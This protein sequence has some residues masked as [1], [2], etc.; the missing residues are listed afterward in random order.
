[1]ATKPAHFFRQRRLCY[2]DTEKRRFDSFKGSFERHIK[3]LPQIDIYQLNSLDDPD[4]FPCDLLIIYA[5]Q[6]SENDLSTWIEGVKKRIKAQGKI[7][8]PSLILSPAGFGELSEWLHEYANSNWY[9]DIIH[10]DQWSSLP[11]RVAN[12]LRI[13]DHL[14]EL[15]RYQ[16]QLTAMQDKVTA[17]EQ[18]LRELSAKGSKKS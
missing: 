3:F 4:F 9:F 10:P 18:E 6:I 13:H 15:Y 8:T 16:D 7:W 1:M 17:I 5:A 2:W 11:I 12:L 14:H